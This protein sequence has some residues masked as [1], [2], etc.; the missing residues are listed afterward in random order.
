MERV[1]FGFEWMDPFV[2][3]LQSFLIKAGADL[4]HV[5]KV[6]ALVVESEHQ[7]SEILAAAFRIGVSADDALLALRNL[8]FQPIA[9]TF[10]LIS[11][12]AF[13]GENAFQSALACHFK[14][15]ATLLGIVVGESN[16]FFTLE[17]RLQ[18]FLALLQTHSAQI[19]AIEVEEI[20]SV[21]EDRNSFAARQAALAGPESGALLH[22]AEGRTALLID[23]K[24]TRLNSSHSSISYA[25]FC[26]KKK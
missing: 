10:F 19:V 23:R 21:V 2:D 8:D 1:S 20:E 17:H 4:A 12:V 18:Q 11:A 26:L 14:Q 25:V 5:D 16:D 13:L 9:R 7:R 22:Q 6:S 3:F 15:L 24:S